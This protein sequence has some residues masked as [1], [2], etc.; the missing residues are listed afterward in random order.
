MR[1]MTFARWIM[2][3]LIALQAVVA[4]AADNV[5]RI[6]A[7]DVLQ[8]FVWN[9]NDLSREAVIVQPD[10]RLNY[11]LV[12]EVMAGGRSTAEV[13]E[14]IAQGLQKYI[15]DKPVVSVSLVRSDGNVVFVMGKVNRPGIYPINGP[16]DVTQALA[17]AGGL[18]PYASEGNIK[19]LRRSDK[20]VQQA[21]P[22]DYPAVK[23]GKSLESNILLIS[24]D[25]V[26]VP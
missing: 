9:E 25:I 26:V 22:F 21:I 10:G 3:S 1:V 4:T 11:P 18:N 19:V 23:A 6:N 20:G 8:V 24:R 7:G 12:G 16:V 17:L 13:S 14:L 15:Q 2:G 5:Y